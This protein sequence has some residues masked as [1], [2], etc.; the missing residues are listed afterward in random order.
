[1][2][3]RLIF[4]R[5]GVPSALYEQ[6]EHEWLAAFPV[7]ERREVALQRSLLIHDRQFEGYA[8]FDEGGQPVGGIF[9]WRIGGFVYIEHLFIVPAEK[10]KGWGSRILQQLAH[11]TVILEAEPP[12]D[13][14]SEKRIHFYRKNGFHVCADDYLQPPYREGDTPFRLLLLANRPWSELDFKTVRSHI[15]RS[16]YKCATDDLAIR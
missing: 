12:T 4:Q 2:S 15:Y 5:L 11:E 10:G 9:L 13:E 1:M 8:V 7:C 6:M 16:V 14:I 3:N